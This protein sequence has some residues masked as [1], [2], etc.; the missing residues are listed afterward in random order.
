MRDLL[1]DMCPISLQSGGVALELPQTAFPSSAISGTLPCLP[2][3]ST[4]GGAS[5]VF[6]AQG[7]QSPPRHFFPRGRKSQPLPLASG[8]AQGAEHRESLALF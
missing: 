6:Q 4:V 7:R 8:R 1:E 2:E 5:M 3:P